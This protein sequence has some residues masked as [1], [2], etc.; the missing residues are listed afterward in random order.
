MST[1]VATQTT[2]PP[3][4]YNQAQLTQGLINYLGDQDFSPKVVERLHQSV[5][6][7]GRH[8]ALPI[9]A[10][11][12]LANFKE[13][14]DAWSEV[15]LVLG[16]QCIRGLL[17]K[18]Q[19]EAGEISQLIFTTVTGI[20]VPSIDAR[21]MNR[22][23]FNK[24]LKRV[25][26]FGLGCVAG[27]AAIS[28]AADYLQGHPREAVVILSIE[29]CSLTIQR[30]DYSM[31]NLVSS[32]LFGD[33]TAAVL[34]VGSQHRLAQKGMPRVVANRSVLFPNSEYVMGWDMG[35]NGFK[36]ILSTDV[37]KVAEELLPL[38]V[39]EFLAEHSL[40]TRDIDFWISHPGGPKVINAIE[41]GLALGQGALDISRESLA[42]IGNL[43]SA[44]VLAIL[45]RT[46]EKRKPSSGTMGVLLA[47]GPGFCAEMVLLQW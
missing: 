2:F 46:L 29:L 43:S 31:A 8:L 23:S 42:E 14:N 10:Y 38:A 37:P 13:R 44:S 28:R 40:D 5:Q 39:H 36:V 27:A 9:D 6:V 4:Y 18:A 45:E 30:Q 25:P 24:S 22:I 3:H 1:I 47:M 20:A 21:L 12:S 7:K 16:E 19:L 33:G 35:E 32:G 34:M 15:A 17:E 26:L 11:P 41:K